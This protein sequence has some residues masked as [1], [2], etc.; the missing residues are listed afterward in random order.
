MT[1][2]SP[3]LFDF[4]SISPAHKRRGLAGFRWLIRKR[5]HFSFF[6]FLSLIAHLALF[7]I[8]IILAPE[9]KGPPSPSAV[10]ARDF[11][12]FR[13]S[14]QE[15]AV[16]GYTPQRL[17]NALAALTEKD[18]QEAFVKAPELDDRLTEREK[19]GLYKR[20]IA[21]AMADF[22]EGA[23]E[24][25]ALDLPLSQYFKSLREMPLADP[26]EDFS[27]V[28]INNALDESARLFRL[29]KEKAQT[30]ESL[31][32]LTKEPKDRPREVKLQ[33][34]E[35]YIL[36]VPGEY[37]YRDSPYLQIVAVGAKLFYVIKGFAELPAAETR[38][39][40][41]DALPQDAQKNLSRNELSPSFKIVYMP[42]YR[43]R[44]PAPP[45]NTAQPS[46]VLPPEETGQILDGLMALPV[47][48]QVRM[49]NRDYLQTYDPDSPDLA[50]LT[51]AFIYKN[52]GMVFILT[53]DPLS[54]G[55]DFLEE[56]YYDNLSLDEFVHYALKNPGSRT[57]AAILL[58]LAASYEFERRVI[59]ALDG[60]LDAA[61]QVLANPS[62]DRFFVH[63]KNVKAYVLR[64]VY[65][66][67]AAELRNRNF[68]SLRS[69]IQKYRDEQL[70]IYDLLTG[71]GGDVKCL[72]QYALGSFY[73]HEGQA[74]LAL[75]T[76]KDIDPSFSTGTLNELRKVMAESEGSDHAIA[77]ISDILAAEAASDRSGLLDR[78]EKFNKWK[79][80]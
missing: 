63:N 59:I 15:Y 37:F 60:S 21:E 19:A 36:S 11:Q 38:Q 24:R 57:G 46:L 44:A 74:D 30:L 12:M 79:E 42:S 72:A 23:G 78:I 62:D 10:Q 75:N 50:L 34:D 64:E 71:M 4:L 16:D 54:R 51:K 33:D 32:L 18:I 76:W 7:G 39:G 67:L 77:Q 61:K 25:S 41:A 17:A 40:K 27:L 29:S 14:L 48:E 65:R 28:Q 31:S 68:P 69:V 80:R 45:P 26:S 3:E 2:A 56:L 8:V 5:R 6:V 70:R 20:M 47:E 52:L 13:E 9:G 73:W 35:G 66:D 55:F 43:P 58:C 22:K 49:F 53:N 1:K